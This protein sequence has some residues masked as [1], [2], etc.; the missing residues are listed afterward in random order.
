M[1]QKIFDLKV[2]EKEGGNVLFEAFEGEKLIARWEGPTD[3][4][5]EAQSGFNG[6]NNLFVAA[7]SAWIAQKNN[8]RLVS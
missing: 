4:W 3:K 7:I 6:V 8:N 5:L 1:A 2:E